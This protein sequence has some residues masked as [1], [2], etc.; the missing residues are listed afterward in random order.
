MSNLYELSES[1]ARINDE[2][3]ATG[4]EL[5][6]DLER[7]LDEC[8]LAFKDKACGIGVWM[9]NI[10]GKVE[11]LDK[12]LARL[13]KR[14]V[15]AENLKAR[16]KEY[17]K[18]SMERAEIQKLDFPSFTL[19]LQ[20]NPP[21]CEIWNE[22][23]I[24]AKFITIVPETKQVDKKAVLDALKR[25]EDVEGAILIDKKTHLRQR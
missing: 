4:G 17:V 9:L 2:L 5:T 25:G 15:A 12:E 8:T 1:L 21:S 6:L 11:A 23:A 19:A 13:V 7:L 20:R 18:T 14:K 10:D 16:L 24:P 3:E 22:K